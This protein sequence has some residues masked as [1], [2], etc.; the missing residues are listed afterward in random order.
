MVAAIKK[1][2]GMGSVYK[3]QG[4]R[5]KPWVAC[6]TL[7]LR[8]LDEIVNKQKR[9]IIGYF[10]TQELAEFSLWN[11]NRNP[12]LF[13]EIQR[14][15]NITFE[16][17]FQEW[18]RTKYKN[19]SR[20]A[21]NGYNAA[22]AKCDKI[23]HMKISDLKTYHFQQIMDNSNLSNASDL[24]LKSLMVSLCEYAVQNDILQKNYA[25]YISINKK[26]TLEEIHKPFTEVEL[27]FLFDHSKMPYVDTILIMIYTGLRIGELLTIKIENVDVRNMTIRGGIKTEAGRNRMIPIHERIQPFI[28]KYYDVNQEY[29]IRDLKTNEPIDYNHYRYVGFDVCMKK[30]HMQHLP[31]DCRHTF[32]T[33]LSNAGANPTAIKKLIGHTN[34]AM[35]E[36]I[37]THKDIGQLRIAIG[38]LK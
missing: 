32:A 17:V 3:L 25:K 20:N 14:L 29:L 28:I 2:N 13:D 12:I 4:N 31:H 37:Y 8:E 26:E 21:I 1:A 34:Y 27:E 16:V 15:G 38:S 33:M 36:R 22:Y 24:K 7:S 30:M 5:R 9:K 6:V 19:L 11:Y 10:E 35:T 18:S 23:K